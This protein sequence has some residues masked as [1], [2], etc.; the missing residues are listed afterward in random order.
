M[1]NIE[2][3]FLGFVNYKNISNEEVSLREIESETS[4]KKTSAK[5]I[6]R[7]HK[8]RPY[9]CR[10]VQHLRQSDFRKRRI[11]CR[12]I[13]RQRRQDHNICKKILWSDESRFC[14]N[15]WFNRNIHYRWTQGNQHFH[16]ETAFQER[17]GINV[18]LGILDSKVVGPFFFDDHL[19]GQMYLDFLRND[20]QNMLENLPLNTYRNFQY[21]QQDGAPAHRDRRCVYFLNNFIP[22]RWIGNSGPI[23]WPARSP[24]LTPMDFSVWGYIKHKVYKT[25]PRDV[26]DL[27]LKIQSACEQITPRM[28]QNIQKRIIRNAISCLRNN[29]G[30]FQHLQ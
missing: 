30:H 15:G 7:R 14:N 13:L 29:G 5:I 25:S 18:W 1:F 28:L 21:F 8:F 11:F 17:F 19:T 24:D 4:V 16:R 22:N 27:K 12:W 10:K 9:R 26:N 2:I 20:L 3:K 6:L 23:N